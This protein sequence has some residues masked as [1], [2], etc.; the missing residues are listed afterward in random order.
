[1]IRQTWVRCAALAGL[2]VLVAALAGCGGET[3]GT[4]VQQV[5]ADTGNPWEVAGATQSGGPSGPRPGAPDAP[6]RAEG[7]DGGEM[8]RL[9]LNTLSDLQDYWSAEYPKFFK[10]TFKPVDRFI[11]WDA[12]AP[13]EQAV[14]FCKSSTYHLV[15]AAY[16]KLDKTIGWDRGKLLPL[17]TDKYGKMA[18]VMVLAHEY[19]HSLQDQARLNGFLTPTLVLEQQ[20][21]CFAGVFLRQV[22]EGHSSH[23]TLNTTDGLNGVLGAAVAVRDHDPEGKNNSHGSAFERVTAV[24]IGWQDGTDGCKTINKKEIKQRRGGLPTSFEEGDKDNQLP[25]DNASLDLVSQALGKIYPVAQ[26]PAYDYSGIVKNCAKDT[27]V[28]PVSYCPAENKIGTNVPGLAARAGTLP[29]ADE[30]LSAMV[31]G[32]YN[33]FLVFISRYALAVEKDRNLPLSGP[34]TAGLRTA[35]LSGVITTKLS[36]PSSDPR[37]TSGDLDSAVSG[38]LSD[39]LAAGDVDG[40]LVPSGYQRLEAFRTGVLDGEGACLTA[41][42]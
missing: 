39:G 16:C 42:K 28:E 12:R 19:G 10:G 4:A 32:N 15:N 5:A 38:L 13:R 35:C 18:V 1:M 23:F 6:L 27:A 30:P 11:S 8:D 36:D 2:L 37:L 25:V 40:K 26:P 9:A 17:V 7:G 20:A 33:A 3:T 14:D 21:D 29:G 41:Y 24:Q 34:D 31:E 22:A